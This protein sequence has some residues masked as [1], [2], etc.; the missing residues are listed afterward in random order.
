MHFEYDTSTSQVRFERFLGDSH[1][2]LYL[3]CVL[4]GLTTG[5][6]DAKFVPQKTMSRVSSGLSMKKTISIFGVPFRVSYR[7]FKFGIG[8]TFR[9]GLTYVDGI[10]LWRTH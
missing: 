9:S 8:C 7:R 6:H 4:Q 10:R 1:R 5:A 2:Y 3:S